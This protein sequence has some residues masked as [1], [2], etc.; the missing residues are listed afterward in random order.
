MS[1]HA[2]LIAAARA[3]IPT[4]AGIGWADPRLAH[5]LLPGEVLER[6]VP[7]RQ[8]EFSAGRAAARMAMGLP[9]AMIA[10]RPD[11]A[12]LW[13]VGICGSISHSDAACLAVAAPLKL[14]RGLGLDLEP[15]LPLDRDLWQ[16]VLTPAEQHFLACLPEADRG[17][18]AKLIFS[19]KEA[20]YKAQ[21]PISERLFGFDGFEISITEQTFTSRF[22]ISV[23][24]FAAGTDLQGCWQI[25]GKHI[26]T[27]VTI[28]V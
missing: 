28:P 19:A 10:L 1:E 23:P 15:S 2:A 7:K 6:A 13:P 22:T 11:R 4:G 21:Y 8:C 16:T 24:G 20:A 18:T 3:I 17:L 26:L 5:P 25:A 9:D 27:L 14:F 12:P